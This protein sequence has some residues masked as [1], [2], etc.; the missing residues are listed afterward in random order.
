MPGICD[1]KVVP[2]W[3]NNSDQRYIYQRDWRLSLS[4]G[5]NRRPPYVNY[6]RLWA[7]LTLKNNY[8]ILI[9]LT[10]P[11]LVFFSDFSYF[12]R[13]IG[14]LYSDWI[15]NTIECNI[16]TIQLQYNFNAIQLIYNTMQLQ[17]EYIKIKYNYNTMHFQYITIQI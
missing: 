6:S 13:F 16:I 7:P 9:L 14:E 3:K 15:I 4:W 11:I 8:P 5:P 17:L 1:I 10:F 12:S 2:G